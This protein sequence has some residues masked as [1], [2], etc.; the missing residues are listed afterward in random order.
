MGRPGASIGRLG[1]WDG[2][3]RML[4]AQGSHATPTA[5]VPPA[6]AA[7]TPGFPRISILPQLRPA[8]QVPPW[9][10]WELRA[11]G[12]AETEDPFPG[13]RREGGSLC[14]AAPAMA[15]FCLNQVGLCISVSVS[16]SLLSCSL[17]VIS[18]VPA[19]AV[20]FSVLLYALCSPKRV[21]LC[22]CTGAPLCPAVRPRPRPAPLPASPALFPL[23][24]L[25]IR[26]VHPDAVPGS[27]HPVSPAVLPAAGPGL[28]PLP[29][30]RGRG[31]AP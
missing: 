19:A 28:A 24:P 18:G 29:A 26:L 9:E 31:A 10:G 7:P 27:P 21:S 17:P 13:T 8:S 20:D 22:F 11:R 3:G 30:P 2:G 4:A 23:L 15:V 6:L 25:R 5:A 16:L 1:N 12:I 14:A